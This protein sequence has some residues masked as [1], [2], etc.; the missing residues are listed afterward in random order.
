LKK[1]EYSTDNPL[2]AS[3][4]QVQGCVFCEEDDKL[5]NCSV[6]TTEAC[7]SG[8]KLL[9]EIAGSE[10]VGGK[11]VVKLWRSAEATQKKAVDREA[12]SFATRLP[13]QLD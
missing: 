1:S 11:K 2:W 5:P 10:P 4:S 13:L 12:Q 8:N 9:H 7:G 3:E 6:A